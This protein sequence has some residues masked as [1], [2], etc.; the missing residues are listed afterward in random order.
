MARKNKKEKKISG[1]ID[2]LV[3]FLYALVIGAAV[4]RELM[5]RREKKQGE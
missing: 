1:K 3:M 4:V 2:T 5:D